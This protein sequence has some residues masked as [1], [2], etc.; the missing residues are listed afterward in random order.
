MRDLRRDVG[1]TGCYEVFMRALW[2]AIVA[3]IVAL[4]GAV[5]GVG[6]A[7]ELEGGLAFGAP[8]PAPSL[9]A[10]VRAQASCPELH[11]VT[12]RPSRARAHDLPPAALA[13]ASGL[14]APQRRVFVLFPLGEG[15]LAA[16]PALTGSARGPPIA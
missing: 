12:S 15:R 3:C 7:A 2:L 9:S 10:R 8:A 6:G 1:G 16:L 11:A 14:A 13:A 5:G 4:G